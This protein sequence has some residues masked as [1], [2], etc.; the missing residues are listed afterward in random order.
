MTEIRISPLAMEDLRQIR[1]YI[2]DALCNE[3]AAVKTV[4]KI[5]DGIRILETFPD[6]GAPLSGVVGFATDYR[7]VICGR[8]AAFYRHDGGAVFVDRVL[9]GRRDFMRILFDLPEAGN[10]SFML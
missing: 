4:K 5:V 6:S 9:Y 3:T 1:Q 7:Y 2:A 10:E 8:Y